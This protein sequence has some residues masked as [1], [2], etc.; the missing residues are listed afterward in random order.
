MVNCEQACE[1]MVRNYARTGLI[2]KNKLFL[3]LLNFNLNRLW[4]NN[5]RF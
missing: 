3:F 1:D 2:K 5:W 4:K